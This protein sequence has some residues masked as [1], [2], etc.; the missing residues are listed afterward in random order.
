MQTRTLRLL[1]LLLISHEL[2]HA[3]PAGADLTSAE[4]Y[5][6]VDGYARAG[7]AEH[8]YQEATFN[9]GPRSEDVFLD[10]GAIPWDLDLTVGGAE[11]ESKGR[12]EYLAA[13]SHILMTGE[14]QMRTAVFPEASAIADFDAVAKIDFHVDTITT[15][16]IRGHVS[17]SVALDEP[18]VVSCQWGGTILAG[19][20]RATALDAGV[21]YFDVERTLYPYPAEIG[22]IQCAAA[23]GGGTLDSNTLE[24]EILVEGLPEAESSV[25]MLAA[26]AA[27]TTLRRRRAER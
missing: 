13:A 16:R 21:Y 27:L 4:L 22:S 7:D 20:T 10:S 18:E 12:I 2:L 8:P 24:Y 3:T 9:D 26:V 25:G 5:V 1:P 15:L 6:V 23:A 19:D 14:F 11:A 17:A